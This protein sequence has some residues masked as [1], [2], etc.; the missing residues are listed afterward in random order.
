MWELSVDPCFVFKWLTDSFC[1]DPTSLD[2][3]ASCTHVFQ[4][5]GIKI[6]EKKRVLVQGI[7]QLGGK[8]IGGSVSR[9][10]L[11]PWLWIVMPNEDVMIIYAPINTNST[12]WVSMIIRVTKSQTSNM[13]SWLMTHIIIL[14]NYVANIRSCL[15]FARA[16]FNWMFVYTSE[17]IT[18]LSM[19]RFWMPCNKE[20]NL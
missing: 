4:I 14:I 12:Q 2:S 15:F 9:D 7:Q 20:C 17:Q 11:Q 18:C 19:I 10:P 5:S 16:L 13:N 1:L 8:Y 6:R 3:M